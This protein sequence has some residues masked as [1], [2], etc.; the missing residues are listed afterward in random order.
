[1]GVFDQIV[2]LLRIDWERAVVGADDGKA[3]HICKEA[4]DQGPF[5]ATW[6]VGQSPERLGRR[7]SDPTD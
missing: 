5:P 2:Q 7:R 6:A 4:M 3:T 1:M